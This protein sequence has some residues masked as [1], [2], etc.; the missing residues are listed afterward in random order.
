M[1]LLND[2]MVCATPASSLAGTRREAR[3]RSSAFACHASREVRLPLEQ[4]VYARPIVELDEPGLIGLQL[5][6]LVAEQLPLLQQPVA[7]LLCGIPLLIELS[8]KCSHLLLQGLP[9]ANSEAA[10]ATTSCVS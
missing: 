7:R 10:R 2:L 4:A 1:M 3:S 5:F 8:P 6:D 9:L